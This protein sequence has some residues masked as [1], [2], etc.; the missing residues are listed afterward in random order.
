G[1]VGQVEGGLEQGLDAVRIGRHRAVL[2]GLIVLIG[3][4]HGRGVS[5]NREDRPAGVSRRAKLRVRWLTLVIGIPRCRCARWLFPYTP[6]AAVAVGAVTRAWLAARRGTKRRSGPTRNRPGAAARGIFRSG[7]N[8]RPNTPRRLAARPVRYGRT[9]PAGPG[10]RS[11]P[12][13]C[14]P[15]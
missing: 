2:R 3:A 6:P 15:A 7:S 9:R 14:N 12:R 8:P 5:R 4:I 10:S 11:P 1:R 13:W